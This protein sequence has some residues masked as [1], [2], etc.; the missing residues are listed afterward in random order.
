MTRFR[1][2]RGELRE[3]IQ[4]NADEIEEVKE[5]VQKFK[6]EA[7]DLRNSGFDERM[8]SLRGKVDVAITHKIQEVENSVIERI[9]SNVYIDF[10]IYD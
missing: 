9:R 2:E 10:N 8:N 3:E 4:D 1:V 5:D 7:V 6:E